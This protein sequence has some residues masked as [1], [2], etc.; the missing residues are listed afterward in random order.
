MAETFTYL[1]Q[2]G[3]A[4]KFN[5]R[6]REAKFGDGYTQVVADGLNNETQNWP[7]SFEGSLTEMTAIRDFFRR[8]AGAK[9]FMWT[10][11]GEPSPLWFTVR[12][13]AF[14]SR[15]GGVYGITAEFQQ[16]F[17]TAP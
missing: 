4:G 2:S 7:L 10:P 5:Y 1:R 13:V 15:G 6:V 9:S 12:D 11:P 8:H 17:Y 3:A 14:I 16:V